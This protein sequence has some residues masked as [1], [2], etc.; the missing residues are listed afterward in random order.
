MNAA[1]A[2]RTFA[3]TIQRLIDESS[4]SCALDFARRHHSHVASISWME[5]PNGDAEISVRLIG[6]REL[7]GRGGGKLDA[8]A[9]AEMKQRWEGPAIPS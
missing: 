5:H 3:D 1:E 6:G 9:D 4:R 7:R 8:L 2:M